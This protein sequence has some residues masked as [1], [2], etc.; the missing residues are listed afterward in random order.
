[1]KYLIENLAIFDSDHPSLSSNGRLIELNANESELLAMI[2]GG[3]VSKSDIIQQVWG[4]KG[5]I[6]TDNSYH[7]LVRAVR[8]RLEEFGISGGLIKT[9]PRQGL[10]FVGV[11][12]VLPNETEISADEVADERRVDAPP[13]PRIYATH[14]YWRKMQWYAG[15][16]FF[17]GI[18]V[19]LGI[20]TWQMTMIEESSLGILGVL[21]RNA[22]RH[23]TEQTENQALLAAIGVKL[24]PG[25][26]AYRISHGNEEWLVVCPAAPRSS[27]GTCTTYLTKD[28]FMP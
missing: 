28:L 13:L 2:L 23:A 11:V 12:S 9:L 6:V 10:K 5:L 15:R 8:N 18:L 17:V 25:E 7:Q 24:H 3:L 20:I 4:D 19:W 1:M 22:Q 16:A 26:H 21:K 27:P 14:R